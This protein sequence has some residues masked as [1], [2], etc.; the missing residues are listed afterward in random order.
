MPLEIEQKFVVTDVAALRDRLAALSS[1][2]LGV[3]EQHDTYYNHPARDFRATGEA[4]RIRRSNDGAVVT[5]K[6]PKHEVAVKTREEIELPL[7]EPE[8]WPGLLSTLGFSEV[9]TVCKCRDRYQLSRPP[10]DLQ[11][12]LDE[13]RGVG[14]FAEVEIVAD[15]PRAEAARDAVMALARELGLDQPESRSYLR[16]WLQ[17]TES[18]DAT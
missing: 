7:A 15:E 1:I 16:M 10:F 6:G 2:S 4:L 5:Y 11:V 3:T 8:S 13:V 18:S 12:A 17:R 9:A 14:W